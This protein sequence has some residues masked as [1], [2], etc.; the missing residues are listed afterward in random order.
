MMANKAN[1]PTAETAVAGRGG[2]AGGLLARAARSDKSR[3]SIQSKRSLSPLFIADIVRCG[4]LYP[5]A[6][7]SKGS[8]PAAG[9]E[10]KRAYG[11][12]SY[13]YALAYESSSIGF[14]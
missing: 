8:V 12:D 5:I 6:G 13:S 1:P 3:S 11:V 2:A 7:E 9:P 10:S 4:G 14:K